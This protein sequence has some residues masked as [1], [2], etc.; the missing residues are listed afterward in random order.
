VPY[1]LA[2][3]HPA[4]AEMERSPG[5][6]GDVPRDLTVARVNVVQVEEPMV[7]FDPAVSSRA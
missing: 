7:G 3:H 5:E 4:D 6:K 2:D 1:V